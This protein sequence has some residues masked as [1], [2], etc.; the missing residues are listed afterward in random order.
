MLPQIRITFE[1]SASLELDMLRIFEMDVNSD[2]YIVQKA[3]P[4][5]RVLDIFDQKPIKLSQLGG[6]SKEGVFRSD[7]F[8]L[9]AIANRS[10]RRVS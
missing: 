6:I 5:E 2:G 10:K 9:M 3:N 1:K 7:I 8:P 4:S